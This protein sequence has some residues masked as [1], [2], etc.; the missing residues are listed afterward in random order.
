MRLV[1]YVLPYFIQNGL[2]GKY[3][4]HR[5]K[6]IIGSI[7]LF[8][9][10]SGSKLIFFQ[11]SGKDISEYNGEEGPQ[12]SQPEQSDNYDQQKRDL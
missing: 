2:I 7:F 3:F 12:R 4:K 8:L 11:I 1:L 9:Y 6:T 10:E 5:K